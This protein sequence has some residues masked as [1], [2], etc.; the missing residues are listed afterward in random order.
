MTIA[1]HHFWGGGQNV[2]G[3]TVDH[4]RLWEHEVYGN[5]RGRMLE[6]TNSQVVDLVV[7]RV[8]GGT[9]PRQLNPQRTEP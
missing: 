8:D 7:R 9:R 1:E 3:C 2:L 4:V 6:P 5:A